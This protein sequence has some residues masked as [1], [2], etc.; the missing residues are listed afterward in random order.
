METADL[1][2][3]K[4]EFE[5]RGQGEPVVL[6]HGSVVADSYLPL[7]GER[8]LSGR[9]R[10]IRYRRR[11]YGGSS[12]S[13][14]PVSIADQANDCLGLIRHLGIRKAHV[15]GHSY[16]GVIATRV[17]LDAPDA[18]H[19]LSLLEP[20]LVGLLP[21]SMTPGLDLAAAIQSYFGGNKRGA[22]EGFLMRVAGTDYRANLERVLPGGCEAA[23]ADG[24]TFFQIEMPAIQEFMT[25]FSAGDL[26][27]LR[28]PVLAGVG[29]NSVPVFREIH[30]AIVAILPQAKS[31]EIPDAG[32]MLQ[33]ENPKAVGEALASFFGRHPIAG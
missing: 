33:M 16:G 29:G 12:H 24:D 21:A 14:P 31:I 32:H 5:S 19:S 26:R 3:I 18:V 10:L 2:G 23:V 15:V 11:G 17:A 28:S 22:I 25:A 8:S 27:R 7:M 4:I 1:S 6:I 30:R 13:R 20:A 9:Y